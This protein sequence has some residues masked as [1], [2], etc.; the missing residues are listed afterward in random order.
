M[1]LVK[2]GRIFSSLAVLLVVIS[3]TFARAATP[4]QRE[5]ARQHYESATR[6]FDTGRYDEAAA[7]FEQVFDLIG[8]PALLYNIAQSYRAAKQYDKALLFYRSYLRRNPDASNRAEVER[9][10]DELGDLVA[11]QQ[12]QQQ[13][14]RQQQQ[15]QAAPPPPRPQPP[16]PPAVVVHQPTPTATTTAPPPPP[17][18]HHRRTL[19][20]A[21]LSL[22][23]VGVAGLALGGAM[24]GVAVSASNDLS[25]A[26]RNHGE[27]TTSLADTQSR[28]NLAETVSIVGYAVGG[29][30][31]LTGIA[32]T[33]I[34]Y[35][36]ERA[37]VTVGVSGTGVFAR[38]RF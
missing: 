3:S 14:Q 18:R 4:D 7:E 32:L 25:R 21:G 2:P 37:P 38:G 31:A 36:P 24:T 26:A 19:R 5:Q 22:C 23:A 34:G 8:D 35:H 29:A 11:Q 12:K 15:R 17:P 16:P 28:G 30:A 10:I 27:F 33:V 9:R 20:I 1:S 6:K 13:Q